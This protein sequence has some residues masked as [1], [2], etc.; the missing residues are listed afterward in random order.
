MAFSLKHNKA[1]ST[2]PNSIIYIY[3]TSEHI[4]HQ[5][6]IRWWVLVTFPPPSSFL[7]SR[8]WTTISTD[9]MCWHVIT[10][11][12]LAREKKKLQVIAV[13]FVIMHH[14]QICKPIIFCIIDPRLHRST[15]QTRHLN[16]Y[17]HWSSDKIL[18]PPR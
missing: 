16:I 1:S 3:S 14:K 4:L 15:S 10:Q 11:C 17:V 6:D 8:L 2:L 12:V 18:K 5:C 13:F 7:S 9:D